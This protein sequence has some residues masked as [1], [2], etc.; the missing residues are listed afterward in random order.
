MLCVLII[1]A[2]KHFEGLKTIPRVKV[3]VVH[4]FQSRR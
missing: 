3:R 4:W 1:M 2:V